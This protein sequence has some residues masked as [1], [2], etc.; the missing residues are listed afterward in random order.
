MG[1][2]YIYQQWSSTTTSSQT[3]I[4]VS[5]GKEEHTLT[6]TSLL[7]KRR[8]TKE[9]S[10]RQLECSQDPFRSSDQSSL[11]RPA[12]MLAK[13]DT[14]AALLSRSSRLSNLAPASPE[15]LVLL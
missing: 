1:I 4:S 6:T 11:P 10:Q 7:S 5:T 8:D 13:L 9:D 12:G 15:L 2:E 14:A 3:Y